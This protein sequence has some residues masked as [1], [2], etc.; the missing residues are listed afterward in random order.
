MGTHNGM[1][2]EQIVAATIADITSVL[3]NSTMIDQ[4]T[5]ASAFFGERLTADMWM[6]Q[7]R[8]L[9]DRLAKYAANYK[10]ALIS[11]E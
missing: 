1:T 5:E 7:V 11:A 8:C 3:T 6:E 2:A 9:G 10:S 4:D